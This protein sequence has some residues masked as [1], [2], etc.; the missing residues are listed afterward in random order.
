[1]TTQARFIAA[2]R[3]TGLANTN[4]FLV[5]LTRPTGWDDQSVYINNDYRFAMTDEELSNFA[6]FCEEANL[7]STNILTSD[8]RI[9]SFLMKSPY[10]KEWGDLTLTF[11]CDS[12][13]TQKKFFDHWLN[14]IVK[15]ETGDIGYKDRYATSIVVSM[16]KKSTNKDQQGS[17]DPETGVYL[18]PMLEPDQNVLAKMYEFTLTEAFP[19]QVSDIQLSHSGQNELAKVQVTF[20]FNKVKIGVVDSATY[21]LPDGTDGQR[22]D[23]NGNIVDQGDVF[24]Q[25]SDNGTVV[26]GD[27][28]RA[29]H[30]PIL[31]VPTRKFPKN[32]KYWPSG[33]PTPAQMAEAA[34]RQLGKDTPILREVANRVPPPFSF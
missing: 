24:Q 4:M 27:Y 16:F 9:Q 2:L 7:P 5:E 11:K 14:M 34:I 3:K 25:L 29:Q 22:V 20:S 13:M 21:E 33:V 15:T 19:T 30:T 1:M 6:F 8:D 28:D 26:V 18:P 17:I 31:D 12:N 32:N 10:Q 23:D